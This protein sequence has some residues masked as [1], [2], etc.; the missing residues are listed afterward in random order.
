LFAGTYEEHVIKI[1]EQHNSGKN[2]RKHY[3]KCKE[4]MDLDKWNINVTNI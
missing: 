3:N 1:K 2:K 4:E